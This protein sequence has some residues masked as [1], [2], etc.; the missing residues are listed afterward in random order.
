MVVAACPG[1]HENLSLHR[2][3]HRWQLSIIG[4]MERSQLDRGWPPYHPPVCASHIPNTVGPDLELE[5][6]ECPLWG[7]I[8]E[9]AQNT[10]EPEVSHPVYLTLIELMFHVAY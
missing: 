6:E 8:L 4:T 5:E 1:P 10:A 9:H 3:S 2:G 7:S